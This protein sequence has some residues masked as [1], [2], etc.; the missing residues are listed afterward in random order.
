MER[1]EVKS[2]KNANLFLEPRQN[3]FFP[4]IAVRANERVKQLLAKS[5]AS[6][7]IPGRWDLMVWRVCHWEGV[8]VTGEEAM[9][10]DGAPHLPAAQ[11]AQHLRHLRDFK[12]INI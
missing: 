9:E 7:R 10:L 5:R 4:T 3:I 6:P 1:C 11:D 2:N 12:S 8:I